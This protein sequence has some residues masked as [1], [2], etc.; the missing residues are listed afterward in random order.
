MGTV[1]ENDGGDVFVECYRFTRRRPCFRRSRWAAATHSGYRQKKDKHHDSREGAE[2][3][4]WQGYV[5]ADGVKAAVKKLDEVAGLADDVR[6]RNMI[7]MDLYDARLLPR[8][9]GRRISDS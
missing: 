7:L 5:I 6:E 4:G 9:D 3:H 2:V 8:S 1:I